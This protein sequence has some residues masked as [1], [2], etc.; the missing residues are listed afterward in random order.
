MQEIKSNW[1]LVL[2]VLIIIMFRY[3]HSNLTTEVERLQRE[4]YQLQDE[5]TTLNGRVDDFSTALEQAN[6]NIE[7]A[8]YADGGS[9]EDLTDAIENLETVQAPY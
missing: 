3:D 4:N 1:V 9:Y 7:D 5:V 6:S 8:Q 2:L